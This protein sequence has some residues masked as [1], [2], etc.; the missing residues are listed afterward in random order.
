[1]AYWP[2]SNATWISLSPSQRVAAMALMEADRK[3]PND[4]KNV[5]GA[6]I[7]RA[8]KTGQ[9]VADQ[10]SSTKYQPTFEDSQEARLPG[11]LKDP[12]F[13]NLTQLAED[14]LNGKTPDWVGGATHYLAPAKTM[15]ALEAREPNKYKDWGPRGSN[16]T[17]YDP[18]T[19]DYKSKIFQDGS[20]AFL[21]PEG[22]YTGP[23]SDQPYAGSSAPVTAPVTDT[24]PL[25]ATATDNTPSS[26]APQEKKPV[27]DLFSMLG[28]SGMDM[29]GLGMGQLGSALGGQ[30]ANG[31]ADT[32][33]NINPFGN[34]GMLANSMGGQGGSSQDSQL[35]QTGEKQAEGTDPGMAPMKKPTFDAAKLQQ[36]LQ[37]VG[38]LGIQQKIGTV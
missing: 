31:G 26:P 21:A 13:Q 15:V 3:D 9:N 7:N 12:N 22:K 38:R 32:L 20:H 5:V 6:I 16:W 8:Q 11:I 34:L 28:G 4:A 24:T 10:V 14:R 18:D 25:V 1:M 17:G 37:Q 23:G 33:G 29:S 30:A 2:Y 19:G 35:A 27:F 36:L